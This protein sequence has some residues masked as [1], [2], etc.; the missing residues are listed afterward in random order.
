MF[1]A[2]CGSS[3]VGPLT[4]PSGAFIA[5]AGSSA[6]SPLIVLRVQETRTKREITFQTGASDIQK[7]AIAWSPANTLVLYSSDIG[8][9]AYEVKDGKLVERLANDSEKEV[10]RSAYRKHT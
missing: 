2:G 6:E 10:G 5:H 9:Y 8:I 4:S 3:S 7:W 1:M